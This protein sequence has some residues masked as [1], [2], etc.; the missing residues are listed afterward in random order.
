M[1]N[2]KVYVFY[3]LSEIQP[4]K[5][6]APQSPKIFSVEDFFYPQLILLMSALRI[7]PRESLIL[8]I[9]FSADIITE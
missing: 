2:Y 6:E 1:V 9:I 5:Q 7:V 4:Q 8:E 3:L